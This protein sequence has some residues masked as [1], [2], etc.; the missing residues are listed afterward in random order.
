MALM[1]ISEKKDGPMLDAIGPV[2]DLQEL[3]RALSQE[4]LR[5]LA[6]A[7]ERQAFAVQH[8]P[9]HV[10]DRGADRPACASLRSLVQC[11]HLCTFPVIPI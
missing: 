1:E 7:F 8:E 11:S 10:E 3:K 6:P 5:R 4:G 9:V 2:K